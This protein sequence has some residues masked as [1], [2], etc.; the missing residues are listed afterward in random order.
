MYR[1]RSSTFQWIRGWNELRLVELCRFTHSAIVSSTS[2]GTKSVKE[3]VV[4][5]YLRSI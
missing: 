2:G 1:D 3:C 4:M 5:A